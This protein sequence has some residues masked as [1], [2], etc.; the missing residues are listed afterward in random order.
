MYICSDRNYDF[1]SLSQ[2]VRSHT[3]RGLA[4][5][6]VE[7]L[8]F[9]YLAHHGHA[10]REE[11]TQ[12]QM[13]KRAF[14]SQEDWERFCSNARRYPDIEAWG[15]FVEDNLATFVVGMLVEDC[16]YIHLQK[17]ASALLKYYPN[18]AVLFA[19]MKAKL[20]CP[21]VRFLSHG[22]KAFAAKEG[23]RHFKTSMGFGLE[24]HTEGVVFNPLLKPFLMWKGDAV[25]GRFA[26]IYP[27]SL[28]WRRASKAIEMAKE[29]LS[30]GLEMQTSQMADDG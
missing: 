23:L 19:M 12:R 27:E 15:A 29:G 25:V 14:S 20:A 7:K 8:D 1:P 11:T 17:S 9:G 26:R 10:L 2:N 24:P 21:E 6:R 16:F 4:R 5:C 13:G 22:P 30:S 18:N 28:F 3:R